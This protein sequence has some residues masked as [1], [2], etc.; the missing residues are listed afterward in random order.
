M[1]Q[2]KLMTPLFHGNFFNREGHKKRAVFEREISNRTVT[3]RIWR[4]TG[5]PDLDYP[6]AESDKYLIHVE[7]NGYLVPLRM[8]DYDMIYHCGVENTEKK[9]YGGR[10]ERGRHFDALRESGGGEAV[11]AALELEQAEIERCGGDPTRQ[12]DYVQEILNSHVHTYLK[13]KE[14]G[15]ETFPDFY[16]AAVLN[17]LAKCTELAATYRA[18]QKEKDA[19][20]AAQIAAEEKAFCEEQNKQ[21]EQAV[22]EALR[23]IRSGGVL[24]NTKIQFYR[25]QYDSS[26]YSVVNYLMRKYQVNVPLRTQGWINE[27]LVSATIQDGSCEHLQYYR[28]K[29]GRYSQKF[30]EYMNALI[31]AVLTQA[32]E[33]AGGEEAA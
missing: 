20:R 15:G 17:D 3:Y 1:E 24:K 2:C 11:Q 27:K 7:L 8:T 32:P 25:S 14:N 6:R 12:A 10:Q 4:N 18:A 30:F 5:K 26:T 21:A 23:V 28:V 13:A 33:E 9:L 16:G 22:S 29:N 19:A 31:Q